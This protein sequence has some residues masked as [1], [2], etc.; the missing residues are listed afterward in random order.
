M[1]MY[2]SGSPVYLSLHCTNF[3]NNTYKCIDINLNFKS[4]RPNYHQYYLDYITL[5]VPSMSAPASSSS[6]ITSTLPSWAA[7]ISRVSFQT[8]RKSKK[9]TKKKHPERFISHQQGTTKQNLFSITHT[10]LRKV[11][12]LNHEM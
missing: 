7:W 6:S 1:N 8:C 11:N 2:L 9:K 3:G 10:I 12:I 5:L 4:N